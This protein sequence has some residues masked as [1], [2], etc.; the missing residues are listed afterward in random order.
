MAMSYRQDVRL[1]N[2]D[3]LIS[4]L[5]LEHEDRET[6]TDPSLILH[7]YQTWG[8]DCPS[9]LLGAFAFILWDPLN[10]KLFGAR[11]HLGVK[12]F[13]YF[14]HRHY[15]A[16]ASEIKALLRSPQISGDLDP[17]RLADLL[18]SQLKDQVRTSFQGILRLPGAHQFERTADGTL[19]IQRYWQLDPNRTLKPK[20]DDEYAQRI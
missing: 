9:R 6:L 3:D 13:Y 16:A 5:D 14:Q 7:A 8:T 18:T 19:H 11:D 2:R 1:D 20:S 15:F 12:P 10:Q 17:I 4:Q